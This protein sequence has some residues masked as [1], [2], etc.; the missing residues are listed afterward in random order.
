MFTKESWNV[1]I[2]LC[3][4]TLLIILSGIF[5]GR[6][7]ISNSEIRDLTEQ[8]QE[9]RIETDRARECINTSRGI[10]DDMQRQLESN[11]G[12]LSDI[13]QR[14]YTIRDGL[15]KMEDTYNMFNLSC[16]PRY[17]SDINME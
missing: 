2:G 14:L 16:S 1:I 13:I 11:D 9:S 10:I 8:L 12:E 6:L 5:I 4:G 3:F 17:S 15:Q 7:D